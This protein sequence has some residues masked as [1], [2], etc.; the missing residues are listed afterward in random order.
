[1]PN[2][3]GFLR[4]LW[5]RGRLRTPRLL[6]FTLALMIAA[7]LVVACSTPSV[8]GWLLVSAQ[9]LIAGIGAWM[10]QRERRRAQLLDQREAEKSQALPVT[11]IPVS[12]AAPWLVSGMVRVR[13]EIPFSWLRQYY[14]SWSSPVY[15][16]RSEA[17]LL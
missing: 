9:T 6:A 11:P 5:F 1:M 3:T 15:T 10:L 7:T 4:V 16:A 17:W 8:A 2:A 14:S 13:S 12:T